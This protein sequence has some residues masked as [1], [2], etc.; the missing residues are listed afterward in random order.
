MTRAANSRITTNQYSFKEMQGS[1]DAVRLTFV[2]LGPC[3]SQS[4]WRLYFTASAYWE[5]SPYIC[6][7]EKI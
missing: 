4:N 5:C 1:R 6:R 2:L 7:R 3:G